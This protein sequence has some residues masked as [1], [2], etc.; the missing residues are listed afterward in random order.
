MPKYIV[1]QLSVFRNV[2]VIEADTE[3]E[4]IKISEVA[5]DNWQEWLG[6]MKVDINEYSDERIAYFEGRDYFWNGV[7]YKDKDGYL[8]Y[9]H[10]S[11][12]DV[13]RKEI[14]IR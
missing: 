4:A 3:E 6:C 8:A 11:G 13:E 1:E 12:E 7:S 9:H 5:D 2:H 14:I 10:P